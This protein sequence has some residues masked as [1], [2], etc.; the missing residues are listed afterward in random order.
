VG[1]QEIVHVG[2]GDAMST[3]Y[4]RLISMMMVLGAAPGAVPAAVSVVDE[5]AIYPEGPVWRNGRLLYVEYA[6][7]GIKSWDGKRVGVFW[8]GE[9]CGPSG[10]IA[11]APTICW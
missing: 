8:R 9:H 4:L 5:H 7:P 6:G 11:S 10:L 1:H 2:V 3:R